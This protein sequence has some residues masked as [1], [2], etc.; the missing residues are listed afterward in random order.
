MLDDDPM[1]HKP[2]IKDWRPDKGM[3]AP[4]VYVHKVIGLSQAQCDKLAELSAPL[5]PT[6][7][8]MV[9]QTKTD[10][11][12]THLY[13]RRG[14][15]EWHVGRD[16]NALKMGPVD[17]N[18]LEKSKVVEPSANDLAGMEAHSPGADGWEGVRPEDR[19]NGDPLG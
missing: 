1:T 9:Q 14:D 18:S 15:D 13:V 7:R 2:D 5:G 4:G 3:T 11:G 10:S 16:G 19:P 8:L 17:R 6:G 12:G